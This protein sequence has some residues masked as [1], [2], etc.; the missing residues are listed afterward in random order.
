MDENDKISIIPK[1]I[2]EN[3]LKLIFTEFTSF[4]TKIGYYKQTSGLSMGG[5]LSGILSNIYM[6]HIE[7]EIIV[8]LLKNKE[9]EYYR[10]YVDDCLIV[11]NKNIIDQTFQNLNNYTKS[12]KFTIENMENNSLNFLD[13]KIYFD[14]QTNNFEFK[15]YQK[16]SKSNVLINSTETNLNNSLKLLK[17]KFI[18]NEYPEHVIDEKKKLQNLSKKQLQKQHQILRPILF[19]VHQKSAHFYFQA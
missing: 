6:S 18:E 12:L 1:K 8:P 19:L 10:R 15:N 13:C 3:F 5:K 16:V 4:Q 14:Q 17:Q 9:I 2:F 11:A 7:N